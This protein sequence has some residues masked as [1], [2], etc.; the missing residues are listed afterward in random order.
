MTQQQAMLDQLVDWHTQTSQYLSGQTPE[1][2][3]YIP[4]TPFIRTLPNRGGTTELLGS[5]YDTPCKGRIITQWHDDTT[6]IYACLQGCILT[7]TK[8]PLL[9]LEL[10]IF[11]PYST[12]L[13]TWIP[14]KLISNFGTTVAKDPNNED[15]PLLRKG[16]IVIAGKEWKYNHSKQIPDKVFGCN[17]DIYNPDISQLILQPTEQ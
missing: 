11:D 7:G 15:H 9:Q 16:F 2:I 3:T 10:R 6:G 17:H 12:L 5:K 13:K 14:Q 8:N 1:G 4:H